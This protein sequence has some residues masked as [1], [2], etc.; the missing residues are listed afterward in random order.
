[1]SEKELNEF[2]DS[3]LAKEGDAKYGLGLSEM[4]LRTKNKINY[5]I[6]PVDDK[7]S[8]IFIQVTI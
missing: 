1:M 8:A 7:V 2:Y 5:L 6:S 3:N 4:R